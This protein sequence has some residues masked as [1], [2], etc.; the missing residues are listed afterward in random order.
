[1]KSL[2]IEKLVSDILVSKKHANNIVQLISLI[3]LEHNSS[4]IENAALAC[5]RVFTKISSDKDLSFGSQSNKLEKM[6]TEQEY[7]NWIKER[8]SDTYSS[9]INCLTPE[10]APVLLKSAVELLSIKGYNINTPPVERYMFPEKELLSLIKTFTCSQNELFQ[11]LIPY[12]KFDDFRFFVLKA[13]ARILSESE[14]NT[15]CLKTV[16]KF[17]D[18]V[19]LYMPKDKETLKNS[20]AFQQHKEEFELLIQNDHLAP[21]IVFQQCKQFT[22]AWLQVLKFPL[23]KRL[24]KEVLINLHKNLIPNFSQPRLLADF[25]TKS[26]QHG[27][28]VALLALQGLFVLMLEHNLEYPEFY[29]NLYGMLHPRI[30]EAKYRARFFH[31]LELFLSTTYIPAYMVAAFVKKMSRLCLLAPP[32][33]TKSMIFLIKNLLLKHPSICELVNYPISQNKEKIKSDPFQ[34][35][36]E[37]PAKCNAT[38][39]SLWEIAAF[40][41]HYNP[42]IA[43]LANTKCLGQEKDVSELLEMDFYDM[44]HKDSFLCNTHPNYTMNHV[45]PTH[46][47]GGYED[48]VLE[49]WKID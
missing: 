34:E 2:N 3:S 31:H 49:F 30:F 8:F 15:A 24:H 25:L 46:L 45:H 38:K 48:S 6:S 16:I 22:A 23:P 44:L 7:R 47:M 1:M 9:M 39:S 14:I 4:D 21:F 19:A 5:V 27:G 20:L 35:S 13:I 28:G 33:C 29:K 42:D 26:Y 37:D 17:L 43:K 18:S 32:P 11:F 12:M 40:S 36:E 41:H 10:T